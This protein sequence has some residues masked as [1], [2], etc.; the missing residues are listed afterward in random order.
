MG[1]EWTI[2]EALNWTRDYFRKGSISAARFEAELLLAHAM[3]IEWLQLYLQPDRSLSSAERKRFRQLIERRRAGTPLQYL[4]GSVDF[5]NCRLQVNGDVLIPRPETEE[6]VECILTD[7]QGRPLGQVLDLGTGSGAIAIAL[8]LARPDAQVTAGDCSAASLEVARQNAVQNGVAD[9]IVFR[10]SDWFA[11]LTG[12][13]DVI[14]ANP[15]YVSSRQWEKLASEVR[16]HEP[17]VALDGGADG[18]AA[19]RQIVR[20]APEHLRSGGHL[21]LE[22]GAGQETTVRQLL[23]AQPA[24]VEILI[25]KDLAGHPRFV[26]ARRA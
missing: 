2:R 19:V 20:E 7:Y 3:E 24:F 25:R 6:L 5:Y 16:E 23:E 22:I 18:L 12:T 1:E 26:C 15:P 4:L 17:A 9:R 11:G 14:V 13:F 10:R 21:Y 8:A